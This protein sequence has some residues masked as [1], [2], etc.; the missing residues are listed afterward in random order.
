MRTTADPVR[1]L[2]HRHRELCERAV[3]PL[4]IAACL[5]ARGVTDRTAARFRHRDV[6]SLAEELYARVPRAEL[7]PAAPATAARSRWSALRPLALLPGALCAATLLLLAVLP[8]GPGGLRPAVA[9]LGALLT[10]GA[11]RL[12]LGR[13]RT[14]A[15]AVPALLLTGYALAGDQVLGELTRQPL[16]SL[17]VPGQQAAATALALTLA[18]APAVWSVRWFTARAD[19]R[20][21]T[22]RS[23]R[24]FAT[25]MRPQLAAA[26]LLFTLALLGAMALA[27]AALPTAHG[28]AWTTEPAGAARALATAALG[29]LLYSAL[30][31][32]AHGHRTAAA[33]GLGAAVGGL[34]LAF[35]VASASWLPGLRP[36]GTPVEALVQAYGPAVLPA[37]CCTAA[38]AGLLAHAA[39]VLTGPWAHHR[40][41]DGP[42]AAGARTALRR[43][44]VTPTDQPAPDHA[45]QAVRHPTRREQP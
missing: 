36:L 32:L 1:L 31:L 5:E 15:A 9:A 43:R 28:D 21:A 7:R 29:L 10:L 23:L 14:G 3:D 12:A 35:S 11:A 41:A 34:V 42:A 20:L 33:V 17:P 13:V 8:A 44:A 6:F 40:A 25:R 24:E 18:A 19:A 2:M 27:A 38:T 26:V 37:I 22:S 39:R 4:E 45:V 16:P 30:L